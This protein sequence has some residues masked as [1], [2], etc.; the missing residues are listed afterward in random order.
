MLRNL[1]REI[2]SLNYERLGL[3]TDKDKAF[4][5]ITDKLTPSNPQD[6]VKSHYFFE[7][8]GLN[9]NSAQIT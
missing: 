8:L 1:K 9:R 7:F 4:S 5:Q 6:A 3:S 2:A